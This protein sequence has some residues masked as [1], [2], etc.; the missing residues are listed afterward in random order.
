MDIQP[1]KIQTLGVE[2]T[3]AKIK[4]SQLTPANKFVNWK[5]SSVRAMIS[6]Y[7]TTVHIK[8]TV[9]NKGGVG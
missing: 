2:P 4:N 3:G 5:I 7:V 6:P 1:F 9:V 8:V